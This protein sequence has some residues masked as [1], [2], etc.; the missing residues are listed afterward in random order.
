MN[1]STQAISIGAMSK[2]SSVPVLFRS[3]F[4]SV[5]VD[6]S[7][8]TMDEKTQQQYDPNSIDF[9]FSFLKWQPYL[10]CGCVLLQICFTEKF[11]DKNNDIYSVE[12]FGH[13]YQKQWWKFSTI[14]NWQ[15][16]GDSVPSDDCQQQLK[17]ICHQIHAL[18]GQQASLLH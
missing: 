11:S 2:I 9:A 17:H 16:D 7:P 8:W 5:I 1:A 18:F 12:V 6:F 15:F 14:T 4:P 3:E 10:S 13:G